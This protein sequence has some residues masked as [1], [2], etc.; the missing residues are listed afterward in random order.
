MNYKENFERKSYQI[1]IFPSYNNIL[2]YILQCVSLNPPIA[3]LT[4]VPNQF[5]LLGGIT[6]MF[7][8]WP[9]TQQYCSSCESCLQRPNHSLWL[10]RLNWWQHNSACKCLSQGQFVL[11]PLINSFRIY[12][13]VVLLP[14]SSLGWR[15]KKA[16]AA[17]KSSII[18]GAGVASLYH[19]AGKLAVWHRS[20]TLVPPT[21]AAGVHLQIWSSTKICGCCLKQKM[22]LEIKATM[23]FNLYF[24]S[25]WNPKLVKPKM[26]FISKWVLILPVFLTTIGLWKK[27]ASWPNTWI[28]LD[29]GY[30]GYYMLSLFKFLPDCPKN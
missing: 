23:T 10:E 16:V 11:N 24:T 20:R 18:S 6:L 5:S 3:L 9:N 2:S 21:D 29:Y 15:N 30:D 28:I 17:W 19:I 12:L 14:W 4:I 1:I 27:Y 22:L 25:Y 8:R 7:F 13:D 26:Q